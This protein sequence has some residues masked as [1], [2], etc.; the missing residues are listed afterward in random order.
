VSFD[1]SFSYGVISAPEV[2]DWQPLVAN[3]SFLVVSSDGIFEKLEVQEV[4]DL[5]WEVNNQTSSGAGVPSYC[6]ISLADCLVNTAFEKGSMDNMAAVVVPL[7]SNLVTQLQRKE[8][9][10]NDNKDKIA[11]ALPCSNCTLPREFLWLQSNSLTSC[12]EM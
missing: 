4:C 2:M 5:L 8:Q 10:M 7:K 6:S 9:S 3:D 12:D 11:S 1:I